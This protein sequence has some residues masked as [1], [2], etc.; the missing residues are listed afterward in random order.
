M[1]KVIAIF[2]AIIG[3][4]ALLVGLSLLLSWPFMLLWNGCL[5]GTVAGVSP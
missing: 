2:V 4:L 1:D 5:V 3:I